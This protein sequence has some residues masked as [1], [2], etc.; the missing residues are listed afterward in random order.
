[1]DV[2][3]KTGANHSSRL[4]YNSRHLSVSASEGYSIQEFLALE[5]ELLDH[6]RYGDWTRLLTSELVYRSPRTLFA[7]FGEE[8]DKSQ[9]T[10]EYGYDFIKTRLEK[11]LHEP[12][13]TTSGRRLVTN[14]IAAPG[15]ERN[16]YKVR[17]YVLFTGFLGK[18][19]HL[20]TCERFDRLKRCT[21][22]YRIIYREVA[23][24][25][26]SSEIRRLARVL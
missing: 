5:A 17:S 20:F 13:D 24:T 3:A 12:T 10:G 23:F 8:F 26:M 21:S 15:H 22:S 18:E 11:T 7:D 9:S 25:H 1:M 14:C 19:E 4:A 16:E 6:H 2:I